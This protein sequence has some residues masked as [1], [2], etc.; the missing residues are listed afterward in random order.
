MSQ[1]KRRRAPL[2][3]AVHSGRVT[4]SQLSRQ[5]R[6]CDAIEDELRQGG[7]V[8][9]RVLALDS[10]R[11]AR[12]EDQGRPLPGPGADLR[13]NVAWDEYNGRISPSALWVQ[14]SDAGE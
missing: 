4:T 7:G 5:R 6:M 3:N 1:R 11:Q 14:N 10:A 12:S 13:V 2:S 8:S 9:Q